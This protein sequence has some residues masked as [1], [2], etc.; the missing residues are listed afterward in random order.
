MSNVYICE[1]AHEATPGVASRV[2]AGNP[3]SDQS[4]PLPH[5]PSSF[6]P[7]R[8][9]SYRDLGGRRS[10]VICSDGDQ[11]S[12][13]LQNHT[14]VHSDQPLFSLAGLTSS[15]LCTFQVTTVQGSCHPNWRTKQHTLNY[16]PLQAVGKL[17]DASPPPFDAKSCVRFFRAR[18][19]LRC[20]L[21]KFRSTWW[22]SFLFPN[23]EQA[24]A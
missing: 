5:E 1:G 6:V 8:D 24:V 15:L 13:S 2:N 21:L 16:I 22:D 4:R 14:D 23:H 18:P 17:C 3:S 10:V 19:Q 20:T 11:S 12:P 9:L 7:R